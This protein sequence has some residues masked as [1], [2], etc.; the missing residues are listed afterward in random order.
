MLT[1]T[2]PGYPLGWCIDTLSDLDITMLAHDLQ[3]FIANMRTTTRDA[4]L[5]NT[6]SNSMGNAC[7]DHRINAALPY[8]EVRGDFVGPFA[9]ETEFN[10]I[11]RCVPLPDILH[12][13]EH[14]I[15]FSHGDL[16]MRNVIMKG[17]KL[18]GIIDWENSGWYPE[19]W[20]YTKAHYITK[21]KRRWLDVVDCVF[22]AFGDH[23][24][25]YETE[26]KLWEYCY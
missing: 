19:Y 9:D 12:R 18:S 10:N 4:A 24:A 13:A 22:A 3:E 26:Y 1:S 7:Y 23:K 15:V 17:R 14:R 5:E 21:H 6:I 25:E 8:D 2:L 16:N 20:D 11:L